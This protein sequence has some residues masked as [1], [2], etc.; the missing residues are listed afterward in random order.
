MDSKFNSK[1]KNKILHS[2]NFHIRQKFNENDIENV[3]SI[4]LNETISE[5]AKSVHEENPNLK[6]KEF[7]KKVLSNSFRRIKA[8]LQ[9]RQTANKQRNSLPTAQNAN[10]LRVSRSSGVNEA[11]ERASMSRQNEGKVNVEPINFTVEN[12]E[13]IKNPMEELKRLQDSRSSFE[14]Q[15][16]NHNQPQPIPDDSTPLD[17]LFNQNNT[18]Q[19]P[20]PNNQ[21]N[22]DSFESQFTSILGPSPSEENINIPKQDIKTSEFTD[23]TFKPKRNIN[24]K[25]V[26][27]EQLTIIPR[28]I[29]QGYYDKE[30]TLVIYSLDRNWTNTEENRYNFNVKFHNVSD[31]RSII[32]K[33]TV[34]TQETFRN[35]V[36]M[37]LVRA[38]IPNER[39]SQLI[40]I[41]G[42]SN[43]VPVTNV[44]KNLNALQ[45]PYIN[46]DINTFNG[47][48][49]GTNSFI[50]NSFT[51]LIV[52]QSY[53]SDVS[54]Q[55]S[56]F[57]TF[58]SS[59]EN[60]RRIFYP[61]PLSDLKSMKIQLRNP[62]GTIL[63]ESQDRFSINSMILGSSDISSEAQFGDVSDLSNLGFYADLDLP[64]GEPENAKYLWLK[65]TQYFPSSS[66][67]IGETIRIT[68]FE[69]EN[70]GN[71]VNLQSKIKFENYINRKDG[72][73]IV[74][75]A[76]IENDTDI[77]NS[78]IKETGNQVGYANY[79]IIPFDLDSPETGSLD[80]I[81]FGTQSQEIAL[82]NDIRTT[83][84]SSCHG[85]NTSRQIQLIFNVITR[86]YDGSELRPQNI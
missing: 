6:L 61:T 46:L 21:E 79:I 80:R 22:N 11:Y 71:L 7:N 49:Q 26:N 8:I 2:L 51:N 83:N 45:Y 59:D 41:T 13:P 25:P 66:F 40:Q 24:S 37:R 76:H 30:H 39:L 53:R 20:Q 63:S 82:F 47:E 10:Q 15:F 81:T 27:A 52:D 32:Q 67:N 60:Q 38:N 17:D 16:T 28:T 70:S 29:Q 86:N 18:Q 14:Q 75:I 68:G 77:S 23:Q 9:S 74:S 44:N 64:N 4:N 35:I 50:N 58:I 54:N 42:V 3:D 12:D 43:D 36:S 72:H 57:L 1:N 55:S 33:G 34:S 69:V 84:Q 62:T 31:E 56:G 19:F 48:I 78:F 85:I 65:T 5:V 73:H